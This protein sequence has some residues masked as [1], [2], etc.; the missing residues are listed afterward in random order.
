MATQVFPVQPVQQQYYT[1]QGP[2]GPENVLALG[3]QLKPGVKYLIQSNSNPS[4]P[5]GWQTQ[6]E[7]IPMGPILKTV[8]ID[9]SDNIAWQVLPS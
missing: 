1:Y 8:Y 2:D 3:Y 4:D 7:T 5:N 9:L 6:F